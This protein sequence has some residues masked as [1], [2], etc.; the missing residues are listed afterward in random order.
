MERIEIA[1]LRLGRT[2]ITANALGT[3][4]MEDVLEC[5]RKHA[6]GDWGDVCDEDKA[7]NDEAVLEGL[8]VLSAYR[9]RNGTKFWIITE[10][11]RSYTTVLLPEDY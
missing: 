3:L 10:H 4:D 8:R 11:D 7:S 9:D 5:T 1:V 6:S 2:V